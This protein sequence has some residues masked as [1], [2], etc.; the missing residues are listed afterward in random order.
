MRRPSLN[1]TNSGIP[2]DAGAGAALG[3][4]DLLEYSLH[5]PG[6]HLRLSSFPGSQPLPRHGRSSIEPDFNDDLKPDRREQPGKEPQVQMTQSSISPGT[7]SSQQIFE[8][9]LAREPFKGLK[10]ILDSLTRNREA[11]REKVNSAHSYEELL[12]GLGYRI[13]LTKQI[14]VQ[15]CYSRMGAA[16]G[17]KAVLPYHD[18]PSHS[19][20]PTLVHFDSSVTVTPESA[21][22][23][24]KMLAA[25]KTQLNTPN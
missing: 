17:I 25:F 6:H 11:L 9:V 24:N 20:L 2:L 7:E 3:Q 10:A 13:T 19:S 8:R 21:A 18:I 14:H 22:F 4:C 1:A 15:D 12:T 16:G 23:F 5:P